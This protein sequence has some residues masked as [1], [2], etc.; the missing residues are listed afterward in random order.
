MFLAFAIKASP[1]DY[2][3]CRPCTNSHTQSRNWKGSCFWKSS[4]WSFGRSRLALQLNWHKSIRRREG[5]GCALRVHPVQ[6]CKRMLCREMEGWSM[7]QT[8]LVGFDE[9]SSRYLPWT[10][11][12]RAQNYSRT[13][14]RSAV[15]PSFSLPASGSNH[16]Q[17]GRGTFIYIKLGKP[18]ISDVGLSYLG[19]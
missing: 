19:W 8:L 1:H 15:G 9:L 14:S 2:L 16:N 5:V 18:Y 4:V 12:S 7:V 6:I 3:H 11:F 10:P 13:T 17:K